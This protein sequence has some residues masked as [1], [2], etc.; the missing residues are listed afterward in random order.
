[1]GQQANAPITIKGDAQV[2]PSSDA[3]TFEGSGLGPSIVIGVQ[4]GLGPGLGCKSGPQMGHGL[5]PG[6]G[7]KTNN[8]SPKEDTTAL[9]EQAGVKNSK[10]SAKTID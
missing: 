9:Q 1:M 4:P 2:K 7:A 6:F 10:G 5:G 8:G 3:S